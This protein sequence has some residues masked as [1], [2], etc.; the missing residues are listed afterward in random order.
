MVS[1]KLHLSTCEV[2]N[3]LLSIRRLRQRNHVSCIPH[4]QQIQIVS[5]KLFSYSRPMSKHHLYLS[6]VTNNSTIT[7]SVDLSLSISEQNANSWIIG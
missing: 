3:H 4:N 6:Q 7:V 1:F 5:L 2:L